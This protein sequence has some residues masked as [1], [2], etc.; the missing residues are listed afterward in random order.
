MMN[1]NSNNNNNKK[2][3]QEFPKRILLAY[4]PN[5]AI[6]LGSIIYDMK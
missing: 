3:T 6:I 1:N 5:K 2:R 4:N